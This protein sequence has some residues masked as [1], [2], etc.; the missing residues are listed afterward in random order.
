MECLS[1]PDCLTSATRPHRDSAHL[2][3]QCAAATTTA[4]AI[5]AATTTAAAIAAA[6]GRKV[7]TKPHRAWSTWFELDHYTATGQSSG[8]IWLTD[9]GAE[10][11]VI[12]HNLAHS[13][14]CVPPPLLC[15]A[16]SIL[17][18]REEWPVGDHYD[19]HRS[20][21]SGQVRTTRR[22]AAG[23]GAERG[24]HTCQKKPHCRHRNGAPA[25]TSATRAR[26]GTTRNDAETKNGAVRRG[27][28]RS[29]VT[30][31]PVVGSDASSRKLAWHARSRRSPAGRW[32][33]T[34][35]GCLLRLCSSCPPP[36]SSAGRALTRPPTPPRRRRRCCC[37]CRRGV[38]SRCR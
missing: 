6:A 26:R 8:T 14:R 30:D 17:G 35:T 37:R 29:A 27:A 13:K 32:A 7:S 38:A 15:S 24:V 11:A 33:L 3:N 36:L 10:T 31:Q 19:C 21:W 1:A 12:I 18:R 5:A 9:R 22:V 2:S 34:P 25:D 28:A 23:T 16:S 20:Q 4:A